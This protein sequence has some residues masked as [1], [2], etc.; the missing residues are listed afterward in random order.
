MILMILHLRAVWWLWLVSENAIINNVVIKLIMSALKVSD[1]KWHK[2]QEVG[3]RHCLLPAV[4]E[5]RLPETAVS[6]ALLVAAAHTVSHSHM[7][8]FCFPS[9]APSGL[10]KVATTTYTAFG[11]SF[12]VFYKAAPLKGPVSKTARPDF[13]N[14]SKDWLRSHRERK[15]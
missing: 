2:A 12:G 15:S 5:K 8:A 9:H 11:T 14:R 6:Q 1:N 3:C 13:I 7:E 10:T 4:T